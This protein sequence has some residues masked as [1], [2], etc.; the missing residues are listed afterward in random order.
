[1]VG[2]ILKRF[3]SMVQ[4]GLQRVAQVLSR[5]TEPSSASLPLSTVAD[6]SG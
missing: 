1:M 4:R 6:L 3:Q 2:R 5:W